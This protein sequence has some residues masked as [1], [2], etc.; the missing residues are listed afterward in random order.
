MK[1]FHALP[2]TATS[3]VAS[4]TRLHTTIT[5]A[6]WCSRRTYYHHIPE[7]LVPKGSRTSRFQSSSVPSE[8]LKVLREYALS[9]L[10][11]A[12]QAPLI[13]VGTPLTAAELVRVPHDHASEDATQ[14]VGSSL[15]R[16][17][18]ELVSRITSISVEDLQTSPLQRLRPS[19]LHKGET[20][21][22]AYR[23]D[24]KGHVLARTLF[25]VHAADGLLEDEEDL[26]ALQLLLRDHLCAT[27]S[28]EREEL[29]EAGIQFVEFVHPDHETSFVFHLFGGEVISEGEVKTIERR[30]E[31]R[32]AGR[33]PEDSEQDA[34]SVSETLA[35]SLKE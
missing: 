26:V 31:M 18:K 6:L 35:K 34:A 30:W 10:Y 8:R 32:T 19:L 28:R 17:V 12:E 9:P 14:T 23:V 21:Q 24:P 13:V 16:S 25:A 33:L 27:V 5:A 11:G 29:V 3:R 20:F 22:E 4:M 7:T 15:K 2:L 1:R